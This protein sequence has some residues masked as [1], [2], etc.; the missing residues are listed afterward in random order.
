[1]LQFAKFGAL[2]QYSAT[3]HVVVFTAIGLL[4]EGGE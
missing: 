1:M 4:V 3:V 2:L